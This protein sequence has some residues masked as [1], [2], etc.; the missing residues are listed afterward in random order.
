MKPIQV[1][2]VADQPAWRK[3]LKM[4]LATI[5]CI[6]VGEARD[7]FEAVG[8]LPLLRPDVMV[9]DMEMPTMNGLEATRYTLVPVVILT[10]HLPEM[11]LQ[12]RDVGASAYLPKPTT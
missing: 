5:N 8:L 9:M 2:L 7:D 1:L 4:M 6:L 12:L 10:N 11:A 3:Q